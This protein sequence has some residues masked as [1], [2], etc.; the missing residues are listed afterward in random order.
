MWL[1]GLGFPAC[2]SWFELGV[3]L[4]V[5]VGGLLLLFV[6]KRGDVKGVEAGGVAVSWRRVE[7]SANEREENQNLWAWRRR[8]G[9]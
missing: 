2:A 1:F 8:F 6:A 7:R 9:V 3:S 5:F 4:V